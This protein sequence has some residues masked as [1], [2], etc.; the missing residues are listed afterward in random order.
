MKEINLISKYRENGEIKIE[1]LVIDYSNYIYKIIKNMTY[2]LSSEDIEEIILD[3]FLVIWNNKEKLKDELPIKPYI[4][5]ITKNIVKNKCKENINNIYNLEDYENVIEDS[6]DI[7]ILLEQ[8]EKNELIK[9]SLETMKVIDREIFILFYYNSMNISQISKQLNISKV[10][11]KT[12]LHR[13]RKKVRK[14]L[15]E[16]GY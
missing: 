6:V 8:K 4:I 13:I 9:K 5:G 15:I 16:G 10:N 11:I 2:C 1:E 12:K 7:Q 3:V 14:F